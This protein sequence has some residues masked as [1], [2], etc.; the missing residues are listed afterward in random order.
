MKTARDMVNHAIAALEAKYSGLKLGGLREHAK[1]IESTVQDVVSFAVIK[2]FSGHKSFRHA[3][4]NDFL[5]NGHLYRLN[6]G[7]AVAKPSLHVCLLNACDAKASLAS[8]GTRGISGIGYF[9]EFE[10]QL[11]TA[12]KS[13]MDILVETIAKIYKASYTW[14]E[15]E[16]FRNIKELEKGFSDALYRYLRVVLSA[17]GKQELATQVW[18]SIFS[19]K[20]GYY[21]LDG[22]SIDR[23]LSDLKLRRYSSD[24][25]PLSHVIGLIGLDMPYEKSL[26]KYAIEKSAYHEFSLKKAAYVSD[27]GDIFKTEE[28]MTAGQGY[29]IFPLG[30]V[31]SR[32]LVAAFPSPLREPLLPV[33]EANARNFAQIYARESK[34]LKLHVTKIQAS[35][36]RLDT[37]ELG[38]LIGG[39]LGGIFKNL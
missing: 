23:I 6:I 16:F 8:S 3:G 24:L 27:M 9:N 33:F 21:A 19:E 12:L 26:S 7:P 25:S 29:A 30:T 10:L 5:F 35:Y 22:K 2:H 11:P 15:E 17:N 14:L 38:G 39:I 13:H 18:F 34:A 20:N 37:A 4:F 31:G 1:G 36:R 32:K 28:Q